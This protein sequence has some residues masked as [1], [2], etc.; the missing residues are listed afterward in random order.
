MK[1]QKQPKPAVPA[2]SRGCLPSEGPEGFEPV[3]YNGFE[4]LYKRV[5]TLCLHFVQILLET[6]SF[7]VN[8]VLEK[9]SS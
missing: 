8:A 7:L 4:L 5:L 6:S 1:E 3:A 2:L 9:F